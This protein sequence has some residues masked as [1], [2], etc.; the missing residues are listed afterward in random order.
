MYRYTLLLCEDSVVVIVLLKRYIYCNTQFEVMDGKESA[1]HDDITVTWSDHY[2]LDRGYSMLTPIP[3]QDYEDILCNFANSTWSMQKTAQQLISVLFDRDS[4][5]SDA[6]W[7]HSG[8]SAYLIKTHD[9]GAE[10]YKCERT[11]DWDWKD[12]CAE[13]RARA[14]VT[15]SFDRHRI[16]IQD[17]SYYCSG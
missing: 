15:L 5:V 17:Y 10:S 1:H 3:T 4:N 6:R 14:I 7:S 9:S 12:I 2:N 13:A 16:R 8:P 11:A